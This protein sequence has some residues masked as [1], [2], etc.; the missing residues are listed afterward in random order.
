M[1]QR[2]GVT[3]I[4]GV[5]QLKKLQVLDVSGCPQF[6]LACLGPLP[7]ECKV[8]IGNY[9]A[10]DTIGSWQ[11]VRVLTRAQMSKHLLPAEAGKQVHRARTSAELTATL[12]FAT[13]CRSRTWGT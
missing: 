6:D 3:S 7:P 8:Y 13:F 10:D 12:N 5:E 11:N 2:T 9:D 1:L 4:R